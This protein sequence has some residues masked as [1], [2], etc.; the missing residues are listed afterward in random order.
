[1]ETNQINSEQEKVAFQFFNELFIIQQL[2]A[3][4]FN[5]VM[6]D[7]LHVSH[8]AAINHL[9]QTGDG[10]TPIKMASALQVTKATMTHTLN[11]LQKHN[12]IEIQ[13]NAKDRRSKLVYLTSK[14][15]QFQQK[16][17]SALSPTLER[18][19]TE[20]RAAELSIAIL[21]LKKIRIHLD[22]ER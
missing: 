10:C 9:I 15:R 16:A 6:P 4:A 8:F 14:G 21:L 1:M 20:C 22:T 2:A 7:N 17:I 3:T 13:P 12:F 5:Q 11:V 19:L 18:V